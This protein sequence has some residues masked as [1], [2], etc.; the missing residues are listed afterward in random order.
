ML[1]WVRLL[2]ALRGVFGGILAGQ[3]T[4]AEI[5]DAVLL[6][7]VCRA[8]WVSHFDKLLGE[9]RLQILFSKV[10]TVAQS[11]R[12]DPTI[13]TLARRGVIIIYTGD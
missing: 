12:D 4:S 6:V 13:R 1:A 2:S 10:L 9:S 3:N 11:H 8:A 5:G 7:P